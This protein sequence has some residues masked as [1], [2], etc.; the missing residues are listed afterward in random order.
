MIADA[1]PMSL[2]TVLPKS[3]AHVE[4]IM[5]KPAHQSKSQTETCYFTVSITKLMAEKTQL[6]LTFLRK[7][8]KQDAPTY[9]YIFKNTLNI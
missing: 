1:N 2:L 4:P 7:N 6:V 9:I 3:V 8:Y 5:A